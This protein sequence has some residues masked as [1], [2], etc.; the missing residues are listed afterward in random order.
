[1]EEEISESGNVTVITGDESI[2][3]GGEI[4]LSNYAAELG[5]EGDGSVQTVS[6]HE[7]ANLGIQDGISVQE[8]YIQDH[9]GQIPQIVTAGGDTELV[10]GLLEG[11]ELT[12]TTA[13][14]NGQQ[15]IILTNGHFA[16]AAVAD[17]N[18]EPLA[19]RLKMEPED[20]P[21]TYVLAV[22]GGE[23][24][25]TLQESFDEEAIHVSQDPTVPQP[26]KGK[27]KK[28]QQQGEDSQDMDVTQAWFTTRDDK[29]ALQKQGHN[30]KQG[31]WAKEEVELLKHNI[32]LY[33]R[34][35]GID[36]PTEIIFEMSKDER[37]DFYR[38]IAKGLQR[39]LFSVY[40][41]VIR[42][43]D[44]KNHIG[45]YTPEEIDKL[46]ELRVKH[47][48]DWATIGAMLGRSASSVK[49]RCRLMRDTCNSG[50]WLPAE[51]ARLAKAVYELSGAK[52]G[53]SVTTG[54]SWASVAERVSTRSEK[55]CRT[56]WLNYLNWKQKGGSDWTR[57]DDML[58]IEKLTNCGVN[59]EKD[60]CWDELCQ[61]WTSA[62]SP[63]W[64]R[65]KWWSMKRHVPD[66]HLMNFEDILEYVKGLH[67]SNIRIKPASVPRVSKADAQRMG[68]V[69][70]MTLTIPIHLNADGTAIAGLGEDG[71]GTQALEL[72]QSYAPG[73][74]QQGAY[75]ITQ[76]AQG[77]PTVS[78][79]A[80]ENQSSDHIIVHTLPLSQVAETLRA[81]GE[82]VSVQLNPETG[83]HVIVRDP[84]PVTGDGITT[85]HFEEGISQHEEGLQQ[86]TE[87]G[88]LSPGQSD[89]SQ[90]GLEVQE[91]LTGQEI[92]T[93][94]SDDF[95][96]A[97][98]ITESDIGTVV[99]QAELV[100]ATSIPAGLGV[101]AGTASPQ[102]LQSNSTD[103]SDLIQ[104]MSSLSDPMLPTDTNDLIGSSS[105]V[106][107]EKV[108]T[109]CEETDGDA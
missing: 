35:R 68:M 14:L 65:G 64:L 56:K 11:G 89:I 87:A 13:T 96:E 2:E 108:P 92:I 25:D 105:D 5:G 95:D 101:V 60:I 40:R 77:N 43:Y 107:G 15:V 109:N 17:D 73:L 47:G 39:P 48:S 38:T 62:R 41:R 85:L 103:E 34:E 37:K 4:I 31:Q 23:I 45:K 12:T 51:E 33:C 20:T 59:D 6:I 102:L 66:Y 82:N 80:A 93:S 50:K 63:Q 54:L 36:D 98:T 57:E 104:N 72:L 97:Q 49:D 61:E 100:G 91:D 53:E 86:L 46:K 67:S 27:S 71:D 99:D 83:Q 44:Q 3:G 26:A 106:E 79:A 29:Q 76:A 81:S 10:S 19:K 88:E 8:A 55:Q 7:A 78:F 24:Q 22:G 42:M 69:Q 52:P 1:M 70:N 58:L 90:T 84:D 32:A 16:H 94:V 9:T 75:L 28:Q 74:N 30:W 21:Q 18:I